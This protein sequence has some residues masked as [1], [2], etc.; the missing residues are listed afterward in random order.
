MRPKVHVRKKIVNI[1]GCCKLLN[2]HSREK[3]VL[4]GVFKALSNLK[5]TISR[6]IIIGTDLVMTFCY[7][8]VYNFHIM[9]IMINTHGHNDNEQLEKANEFKYIGLNKIFN[10]WIPTYKGKGNVKHAIIVFIII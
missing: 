9:T 7:K 5:P 2:L 8:Y 10:Q 1:N 4:N 3:C 6:C